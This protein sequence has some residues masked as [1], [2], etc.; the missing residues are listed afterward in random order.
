MPHPENDRP[1]DAMQHT[2]SFTWRGGAAPYGDPL[3]VADAHGLRH[4]ARLS[5][6]CR[7]N[8]RNA[9]G[10]AEKAAGGRSAPRGTRASERPETPAH[11]LQT[12]FNA[13]MVE[14]RTQSPEAT[15]MRCAAGRSRDPLAGGPPAGNRGQR[16]S[17][18]RAKMIRRP[19]FSNDHRSK[20]RGGDGP[21]PGP[22][23]L[24]P[25]GHRPKSRPTGF[26]A[27]RDPM[28]RP[29]P[30]AG[31]P[32]P[33]RSGRDQVL[34]FPPSQRPPFRPFPH[35]ER[36]LGVTLVTRGRCHP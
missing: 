34:R 4:H 2:G 7:N 36:G 13:R 32:S 27:A 25:R 33:A 14:L 30:L 11:F 1:R 5:M 16:T 26:A 3:F 18:P 31:K 19:S 15:G 12:Y 24:H 8:S 9:R 22:S 35:H 10:P 29:V 6:P 17:P 21:R 23:G 28:M 20:T